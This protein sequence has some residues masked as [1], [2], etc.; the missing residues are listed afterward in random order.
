MTFFKQG[1]CKWS[2]GGPHEQCSRCIKQNQDMKQFIFPAAYFV[3][4][5]DWLCQPWV[6]DM[7]QGVAGKWVSFYTF[8]TVFL[9]VSHSAHA[10]K[11]LLPHSECNSKLIT[12]YGWRHGWLHSWLWCWNGESTACTVCLFHL[13]VS[14]FSLHA[15]C[16]LTTWNLYFNVHK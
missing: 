2:E 14:P 10:G 12:S 11:C 3:R 9:H 7:S 1:H 6:W 16:C 5:H 8:I 13:C 4:V 15:L